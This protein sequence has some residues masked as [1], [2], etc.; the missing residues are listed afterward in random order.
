MRLER[1]V[2]DWNVVT[3][4]SLL[5]MRPEDMDSYAYMEEQFYESLALRASAPDK[6]VLMHDQI[7]ETA[8][9]LPWL[10]RYLLS[11]GYCFGTL[12]QIESEYLMG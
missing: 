11:N 5:S 7:K 4:D 1:C 9:M 2:F 6:I 3:N 8:E 10:I 12:D